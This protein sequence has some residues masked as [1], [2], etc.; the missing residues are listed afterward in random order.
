LPSRPTAGLEGAQ[1]APT[2]CW[3]SADRAFFWARCTAIGLICSCGAAARRDS[4]SRMVSR[5]AVA[6]TAGSRSNSCSMAHSIEGGHQQRFECGSRQLI[7]QGVVTSCG[8]VVVTS[9]TPQ[10]PDS[11][12][13][14]KLHTAEAIAAADK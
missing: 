5:S 1:P 3:R 11:C 4:P 9:S 6:C 12:T 13:L 10:E 8:S 2:S 14:C 7:Q